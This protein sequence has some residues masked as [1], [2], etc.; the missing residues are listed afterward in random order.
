[1]I[2][3]S[4]DVHH[5]YLLRAV[6]D[7][8]DGRA[9]V[10]Q[11]VCSPFRNALGGHERRAVRVAI[12]RAGALAGGALARLARAPAEPARWE[13]VGEGPWFDNQVATLVLD[14]RHARL[15]LDRSVGP[16]DGPPRL[17]RLAEQR[18]T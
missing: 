3:L 4:G 15:A 18:L 5:A 1:V 12:S 17:E 13:P 6:F 10:Y 9:P 16:P 14:G 11:A 8:D 2:L 7:G